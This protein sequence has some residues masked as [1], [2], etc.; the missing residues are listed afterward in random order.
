MGQHLGGIS[1]FLS[2]FFPL[3][4]RWNELWHKTVDIEVSESVVHMPGT[5]A[6]VDT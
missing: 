1:G 3:M 4:T 2:L 6:Y 5:L